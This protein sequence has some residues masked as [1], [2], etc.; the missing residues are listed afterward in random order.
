MAND[1][2]TTTPASEDET[3]NALAAAQALLGE[4]DSIPTEAA[5]EPEIDL[6]GVM[7]A[8][9]AIPQTLDPT[10]PRRPSKRKGGKA[11]N[12]FE[13]LVG[14]GERLLVHK[15]DAMNGQLA[16]IGQYAPGD[17]M[18]A[19]SVEVFLKDYVV[20]TFDYG[21]FQLTLLATNGDQ[22]PLGAVKIAAPA[23]HQ[24]G[25]SPE[26]SLKELLEL[27]NK[28]DAQ[29]AEE[30]D[31]NMKNMAGML[32]MVKAM[33]PAQ[34]EGAA[35]DPMAS[36]M[37][38]MMMMMMMGNK[39]PAQDPMQQFLMMKMMKGDDIPPPSAMP[40][41]M[42]PPPQQETSITDL[43]A[44]IKAVQP[45]AQSTTTQD[46][47]AMASLFKK[48]ESMGPKDWVALA[49]M[50]K[51]LFGANQKPG[52]FQETVQ[53]MGMLQ[54]LL[55]NHQQ[56]EGGFWEFA[57]GLAE[58]L[59]ALAEA[60]NNGKKPGGAKTLPGGSAQPAGKNG[61][62]S[63]PAVPRNFIAH[64]KKMM[65]AAEQEDDGQLI[66]QCLR[67][68]LFLREK[69]PAW[70][71]YVESC[72][73]L[74][75]QDE[76]EK[77]MKFLE[78]FLQT[79]LDKRFIT[80][81]CANAT[82]EAFDNNWEQVRISLGFAKEDD[83]E[84]TSSGNGHD[85]DAEGGVVVAKSEVVAEAD[86]GDVDEDGDGD[87]EP[88]EIP[89]VVEDDE[90]IE[91]TDDQIAELATPSDEIEEEHPETDSEGGPQVSEEIIEHDGDPVTDD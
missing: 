14:S 2:P 72:M 42:P 5:A 61:K 81:E 73:T 47:I 69:V 59:P 83:S 21:E 30:A 27:K 88:A 19:G 89:E 41:P 71:P 6:P 36:M 29:A 38:M 40:M 76:K 67:G 45:Q 33:Q 50:I 23:S 86:E 28:M 34:K 56:E 18:R 37:P 17:L 48:D 91:M 44:L 22:K 3:V 35:A 51:E 78:V 79:F 20:P 54:G 74:V 39:Q 68:M 16:Y 7:E 55:S 64:S 66:E 58:Q 15:R 10:P 46:L 60:I 24:A 65:E 11:K 80:A 57:S 62:K 84:E 49:P 53:N 63:V 25:T 87:G 77:A 70:K 32:T 1:T 85:P 75:H 31:S 52:S 82:F 13:K 12:P 90:E 9:P 4:D 26:N 8:P 43:A